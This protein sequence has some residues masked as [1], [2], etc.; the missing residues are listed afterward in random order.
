M[1]GEDQ[2]SEAFFS[3]IPV[4][5][6]IPPD[7]PLRAVRMLTAAGGHLLSRP[8]PACRAS[9]AAWRCSGDAPRLVAGE[10]PGASDTAPLEIGV[11]E[12]LFLPSRRTHPSTWA[13]PRWEIASRIFRS[14]PERPARSSRCKSDTMKE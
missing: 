4:E 7:H 11:G 8:V 12:R 6:R 1:R 13:I 2:R 14:A 5:R 3:Y 9:R 10:R